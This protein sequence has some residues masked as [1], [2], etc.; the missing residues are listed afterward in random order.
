M[1]D[2]SVTEAAPTEAPKD[3]IEKIKLK[4]D[5]GEVEVNISKLADSSY[6]LAM[7]EGITSLVNSVGMSK[8]MPGVTKLE[9]KEKTERVAAILKQAQQNVEALLAG[10]I[11]KRGRSAVKASGAVQTEAMRLAKA[12]VKDLI[13]NSG[14]KIGAY[15]AKEITAAAKKVLEA[16]PE[17]IK[18]A[19]KNLEARAA[20]AKG[21]G[22]LDLTNM[23]G[24]KASSEEVKA[25]PKVPPKA[26][27][28]GDKTLSATQAGKVAPRQKPVPAATAH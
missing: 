7:V 18:T 4:G 22:G 25:K 5:V 28:K 15:S 9:G 1:T 3:W 20:E 19:E 17:L 10:T 8:I 27:A 6:K 11:S 12:M 2:V 14:Q 13:R 26:K 21:V 24:A 23:F 16:N